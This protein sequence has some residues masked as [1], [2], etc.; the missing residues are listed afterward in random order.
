MDLGFTG[1]LNERG[2][3]SHNTVDGGNPAPLK[4]GL[5]FR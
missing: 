2:C 4:M 5:G 1:P 3:Y